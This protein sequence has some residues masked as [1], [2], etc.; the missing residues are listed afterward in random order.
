MKLEPF[1]AVVGPFLEGRAA[2]EP[3]QHALYGP[4]LPTD[5]GRLAIYQRFCRE[6][7]N[8]ATAGVHQYLR[9]L[10]TA[11]RGEATWRALVED[12]FRAH[13]M[14][15]PEI[16]QNGAGLSTWL[17]TRADVPPLWPALA[18]FE[19][20]EWQTRVA[21]D[22][23]EDAHDEGPL[24][25]ASTVELRPYAFDLTRW[26]DHDARSGEPQAR[27]VLVLFWRNRSL[28]ARRANASLEELTVLK[29]VSEG[30]AVEDLET[31]EDLHA[32]GIVLGARP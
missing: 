1:Y 21:P 26:I 9:D 18:D 17:S 20:W 25:L 13:P 6:H 3:T 30:A 23:A 15:H 27:Q 5:A 28:D 2:L 32:A 8:T 10:V 14:S 19:W 4:R 11:Q 22:V 24:R 12:Y 7:R 16:N 31:F 29:Q